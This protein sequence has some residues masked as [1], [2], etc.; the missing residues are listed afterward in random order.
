MTSVFHSKP[1]P[2][3]TVDNFLTPEDFHYLS[4][5]DVVVDGDCKIKV[6]DNHIDRTG[7]V[8][9]SS[10]I[11]PVKLA[12]MNQRYHPI[13][14]SYMRGLAPA[15]ASLYTH[16]EFHIVLSRDGYSHPIHDDTPNKLLS[17]VVYLGPEQNLGTYL[18]R[19]NDADQLEKIVEWK[20]NRA[21]LFARRN[22][23]TW[24]SDA[25]LPNAER[26]TLVYNLMTT[27]AGSA[28]VVE[29][30]RPMDVA[31]FKVRSKLKKMFG[32]E[33]PMIK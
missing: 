10:C 11:D 23:E 21:L 18:Y 19:A 22:Q 8:N 25:S 13:M 5:I 2:H 14:M 1:W 7:A 33:T 20:P 4:S 15:K 24:H 31:S 32:V 29:G 16:S 30:L 9:S 3:V 17:C 6:L 28:S 26:L 12:E 27:H